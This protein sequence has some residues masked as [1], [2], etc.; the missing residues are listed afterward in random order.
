MTRR[1]T[2]H[3]GF[4]TFSY[5]GDTL[6]LHTGIYVI[7]PKFLAYMYHLTILNDNTQSS[8]RKWKSDKICLIWAKNLDIRAKL[9]TMQEIGTV[10][11]WALLLISKF[12]DMSKE[13]GFMGKA[14]EVTVPISFIIHS[15]EGGTPSE[16]LW[17]IHI[18]SMQLYNFSYRFA[19]NWSFFK[20]SCNPI[21]F[22]LKFHLKM[23]LEWS[24]HSFMVQNTKF[25]KISNPQ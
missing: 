23:V 25:D 14:Q 22:D 13:L 12:F 24:K 11:S 20:L 7:V 1:L 2:N 16:L 17:T 5:H 10:T 4:K 18:L 15:L 8:F 6:T 9:W 3:L 21:N 19:Q